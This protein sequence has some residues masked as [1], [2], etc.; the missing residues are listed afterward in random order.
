[1]KKYSSKSFSC[2]FLFSYICMVCIFQIAHVEANNWN[3]INHSSTDGSHADDLSDYHRVLTSYSNN[4][5]SVVAIGD[6]ET[7]YPSIMRGLSKSVSKQRALLGIDPAYMTPGGMQI[8]QETAKANSIDFQCWRA[9]DLYINI[10]PSDM[11][12]IDF[13]HTYSHLTYE[14][15][16]F[17]SQ[18]RRYICIYG[19][20]GTWSNQDQNQY[21]GSYTEHDTSF[22][23]ITS[24]YD[25]SKKGLW[26]AVL[27]FLDKHPEWTL[28]EQNTQSHGFTV[29]Q[30]LDEKRVPERYTAPEIEDYLKN[31]L[32]LCTG[33]SLH[34]YDMLKNSVECDLSLVPYKKVFLTT[35]DP[36]IMKITFLGD[37]NPTK[38][39]LI[40][41][42]GK[43]VDCVNAI[44]STM[45]NAV[46][47]PDIQDDDII[48]FKH[49]TVVI[50]DLGLIKKA[51]NKIVNEGYNMVVR[52]M[53]QWGGMTA[54]D[55]FFIKVSAIREVIEDYPDI[56][57]LPSDGYY[58]CE[59]YFHNYIVAQISKIYGIH[60]DHS[61]G[62]FTELGFFHYPSRP[63]SGRHYWNRKGYDVLFYQPSF[64][65]R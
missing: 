10:E 7:W 39:Y 41:D 57:H 8:A 2:F 44:I 5:S 30:R 36:S 65:Q 42:R 34:R 14:L 4:C 60:F 49:E 32:I 54:T 25:K 20:N 15:E 61:N 9:Y 46:N 35:N 37:R 45:R 18:V 27:D 22:D 16:T 24:A 40:R 31:K 50:N 13:S 11:L 53:A 62:D 23:R 38:N 3:Y 26:P 48:L 56:T 21:P 29:L 33:P 55:A 6:I 64:V 28:V 63:E 52:T 59:R 43:Q 51:L 17:A 1:M 12:C 47:D 58:F 19:T